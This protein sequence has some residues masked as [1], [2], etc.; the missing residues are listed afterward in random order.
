MRFD[1]PTLAHAW[2]AVANAAGTEKLLPVLYKTVAIEEYDGGV[3]LIATDRHTMLLTAWVPELGGTS[4]P[5]IEELPSRTVIA[6]DTDG[7][8]RSMLGY[9]ISLANRYPEEE[10]VEG[11]VEAEV[12][13][14]VR[15]PAGQLGTQA[16][17][18]GME[19]TFCVLD[20]KDVERVYLQVVEADYVDWRRA[21]DAFEPG[22]TRQVLIDPSV[23]ERLAKVAKHAPGAIQWTFST[24]VGVALVVFTRSDPEVRGL[25]LP[26]APDADAD[27]QECSTC[28]EGG[29]CLRHAVGVATAASIDTLGSSL[30]DGES[31]TVSAPDL[32]TKTVT[33]TKDDVPALEKVA[34]RL[35][36]VDAP[37]D[38]DLF[39]Q[40]AR[41][42][43]STQFGSTAML[44]RKLRIGAAKA[45]RIMGE[46]EAQ[47]FVGPAQ[48]SKA[49]DV[50]VRADEAHAA[51]D[52]AWPEGS[53]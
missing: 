23:A 27:G 48:V 2:L 18:E 46:L 29:F 7:R 49:R 28:A 6:S 12:R 8:A 34:E 5:P 3:R 10:Y 53:S 32:P 16:T 1:A 39:R 40:A 22:T 13:F 44:Q 4:E 33:F 24:A 38:A 31:L 45:S 20:S 11:Q 19:P 37:D 35:R 43:T 41:L 14:D 52:A 25:V 21:M 36:A 51:V 26:V 9:L 15:L 42:V 30:R 50:L 17:L 47:G